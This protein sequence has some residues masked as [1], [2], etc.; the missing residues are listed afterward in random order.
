M[1]FDLFKNYMISILK[2]ENEEVY[3]FDNSFADELNRQTTHEESVALLLTLVPH[4][5]PSFL[6]EIIKEVHPEGGDLPELGG[7]RLTNHRGLLPTGETVQWILGSDDIGKRLDI[8]DLFK[9]DHWFYK[10]DILYLESVQ[11]GEPFMSGRIILTPKAIS[12]LIYGTELTEI[13]YN[14][15]AQKLSTNL[16]WYDLVLP[17]GTKRQIDEIISWEKK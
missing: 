10:D 16:E 6:D 5:L 1:S 2:S 9:K 12:L 17:E 13:D 14:F 4:I 3:S 15:P 8:I 11:E 7:V